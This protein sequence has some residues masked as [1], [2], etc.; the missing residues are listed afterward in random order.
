VF[1]EL[2]ISF[3]SFISVPLSEVMMFTSAADPENFQNTGVGYDTFDTLSKTVAFE[4]EVVW[5]I[6]F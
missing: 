4:L 1:T 6:R 3:G 5:T 2:E